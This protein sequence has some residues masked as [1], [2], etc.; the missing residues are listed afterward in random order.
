L[1]RQFKQ[2]KLLMQSFWKLHGAFKIGHYS[3]LSATKPK[4]WMQYPSIMIL[5]LF[6]GS[7]FPYIYICIICILRLESNLFFLFFCVTL[8]GTT[9]EAFV[10][11]AIWLALEHCQLFI[12]HHVAKIIET[13][14]KYCTNMGISSN[15]S[16]LEE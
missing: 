7:L 13:I 10:V 9:K 12:H 5:K 15:S 3:P 16:S 4:K 2:A 6:M 8:W 1:L 11:D 14:T